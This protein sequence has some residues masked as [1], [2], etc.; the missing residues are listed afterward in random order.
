MSKNDDVI[1][2][3]IKNLFVI[4]KLINYSIGDTVD[5]KLNI[6][7]GITDKITNIMSIKD[8]VNESKN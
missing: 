1:L 4:I 7:D 2:C 6:I 5:Y 8:S 3:S